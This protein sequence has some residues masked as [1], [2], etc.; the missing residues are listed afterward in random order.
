M[1]EHGN[2]VMDLCDECLGVMKNIKASLGPT[3]RFCG[4][5]WSMLVMPL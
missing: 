1:F 3:C 4:E 2:F 5:S